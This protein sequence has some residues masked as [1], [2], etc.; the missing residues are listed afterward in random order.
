MIYLFTNARDEPH[1]L[2]WC[3]HHILL[4]F[5]RIVIFDHKSKIPISRQY[6]KL[7]R[8]PKVD[9][10]ICKYENNVKLRCMLDAL[11]IATSLRVSWFIYLDADEFIILNQKPNIEQPLNIKQFLHTIPKNVDSLALN[12]LMFGSN[13]LK[14]EPKG[15]ILNS[16]TKSDMILNNNVKTFV[17]PSCVRGVNN[18][19]FYLM[20]N[21]RRMFGFCHRKISLN[22]LYILKPPYYHNPHYRIDYSNALAYV[23]HYVYQSEESYHKRKLLRPRDD[24]GQSYKRVNIHNLHNGTEN[25]NPS[26]RYGKRVEEAMRKL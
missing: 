1:L 9:I 20:K 23:A 8:H 18:P 7:F 6:P 12:W 16:Y 5:D 17:R 24:T 10:R 26:Q 4:G 13:H 2:E 11:R 22:N 14:Q 3:L 19:H 15:L 25:L 21:P